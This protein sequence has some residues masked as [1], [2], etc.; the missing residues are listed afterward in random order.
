VQSIPRELL[1]AL[2]IAAL[3]HGVFCVAIPLTILRFT[4]GVALPPPSALTV[5]G[6]A[7]IAIGF[8]LYARVV[9]ELV[10][11]AGVSASPLAAPTSLR[12]EGAYAWSRNPL[13]FGVVLILFGEA[14]V[15]R[16][17]P[18]AIYAAAY[19][20]WLHLF[21]TFK[22]EPALRAQFGETYEAYCRRVPRWFVPRSG[23]R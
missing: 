22:E 13:L 3:L 18:L 5:V 9:W 19:W 2:L 23:A 6:A 7:L 14:L 12:T 17:L 10:V 4:A 21:L 1:K 20:T 16:S 11:L 8:V 15:F